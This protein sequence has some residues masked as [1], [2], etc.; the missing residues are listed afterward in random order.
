MSKSNSTSLA[1]VR[2]IDLPGVPLEELLEYLSNKPIE[3]QDRVLEL[4][5]NLTKQGAQYA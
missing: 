4:R 1:R 2:L 5:N 3:F